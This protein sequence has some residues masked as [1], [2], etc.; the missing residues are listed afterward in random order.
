MAWTQAR[1][2][3]LSEKQE[4]ILRQWSNGTHTPQHL[5]TRARII[6][7]SAQGL[8]NNGIRKEIG[9]EHNTVKKWRNRYLNAQ[10][11]LS[12]IEANTPLKLRSAMQS[13]LSDEQR[14]G[15]PSKFTDEQVA[16]IIAIACEEP[17]KFG[18]P[19]SHW[20]PELLRIE[21]VK[22]GIV[23]SISVRHIG[24]FLKRTRF[25]AASQPV[26]AES[27]YRR[28]GSVSRDSCGNL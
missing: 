21:V 28:Y 23:D 22:L 3:E 18:L 1:K 4:T 10:V 14:P 17:S 25:T 11:E 16:A 13:S 27:K 9:I 12:T 19:F 5:K 8:S 26:L 24:R 7:M 2:I 6:L 15:G 20:T